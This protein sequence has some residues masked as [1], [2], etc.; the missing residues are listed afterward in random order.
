MS[1]RPAAL[2]EGSSTD[3]PAIAAIYAGHVRDGA[4]SF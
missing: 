2:R 1:P 4:G 3:I